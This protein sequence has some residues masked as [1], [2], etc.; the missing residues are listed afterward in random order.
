MSTQKG[1][2]GKT[3]STRE[4]LSM[5]E[6]EQMSVEDIFEE[7]YKKSADLRKRINEVSDLLQQVTG[8]S[9]KEMNNYINNPQ[10]FTS[11]QWK[12]I[13]AEK[14]KYRNKLKDM[15]DKLGIDYDKEMQKD[16]DK[17]AAK[18][19]HKSIGMRKKG[20]IRVE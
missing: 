18:K 17:Q 13:Q 10:N 15:Y 4:S 20:W 1:E 16:Q 8:K 7:Y 9:P 3:L 14:E 19:K 12:D 2:K 6:I 5:A 11:Q